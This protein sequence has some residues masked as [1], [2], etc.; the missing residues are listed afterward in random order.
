MGTFGVDCSQHSVKTM[1]SHSIL[2]RA[3]SVR[4]PVKFLF[5]LLMFCEIILNVD[6]LNSIFNLCRSSRS[7]IELVDTLMLSIF[8]I[9][10]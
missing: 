8:S 7:Q 3:S 6:R 10:F 4:N 2:A 9:L 5:I 1:I